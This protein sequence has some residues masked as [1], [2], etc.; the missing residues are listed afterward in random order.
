M[1]TSRTIVGNPH[2]ILLILRANP[3]I[4]RHEIG[5]KLGMD[6][7]D[8]RT[9]VSR[10]KRQGLVVEDQEL[11]ITELGERA[12]KEPSATYPFIVA[13]QYPVKRN[14]TMVESALEVSPVSVFDLA[15]F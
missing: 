5:R 2:R 3:G 9:Y 6:L 10:L 4:E 13:Q 8:V 15:R 7:D 14:K 1:S 11:Q 12:M